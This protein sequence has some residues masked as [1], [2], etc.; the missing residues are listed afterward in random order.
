MSKYVCVIDGP[1]NMTLTK[2][3]QFRWSYSGHIRVMF[4]AINTKM[5]VLG[6]ILPRIRTALVEPEREGRAR[7]P[8]LGPARVQRQVSTRHSD[9]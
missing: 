4:C 1:D 2:K 5:M 9:F 6:G 3:K 7:G 8:A